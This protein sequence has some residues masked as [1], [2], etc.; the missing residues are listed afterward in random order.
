MKDPARSLPRG[1]AEDDADN[2]AS[3]PAKRILH[4]FYKI[5]KMP[6]PQPDRGDAVSIRYVA[7]VLDNLPDVKGTEALVLVALADYASDDT[8]EC[9]PSIGTLARRARCDRRTAQ[10]CLKSLEQRGLIDRAIGGHQYGK[11]TASRYRLKFDYGGAIVP[12]VDPVSVYPQVYPQ[13]R[14]NAAGGAA[15]VSHK[16]GISSAQ[17][18][19][20]AAPS[21]IDP[22][23]I[24]RG[25]KSAAIKEARARRAR[26]LSDDELE[27][28]AQSGKMTAE[29]EA[30]RE[31]RRR[32]RPRK[33][34]P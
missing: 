9:W 28:L 20:N 6:P 27:E 11:N 26:A 3:A 7:T 12:D 18:R 15:P 13:G 19:R 23:L 1:R 16:G 17:G 29:E 14:R 34:A 33:A 10:R 5:W 30:E 22:S 25:A 21:V 4:P 31:Q 2:H 32:M 8:R 24:Q